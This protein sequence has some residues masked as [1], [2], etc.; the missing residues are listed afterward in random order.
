MSLE[1]KRSIELMNG[2]IIEL[3]TKV[4]DKSIFKVEL[5]LRAVDPDTGQCI[6][7]DTFRTHAQHVHVE[8]DTLKDFGIL[9]PLG[10]KPSEAPPAKFTAEELICELLDFFGVEYEG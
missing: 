10:M 7:D 8:R 2:K 1:V 5:R 9:V 4:N 3:P 6:L